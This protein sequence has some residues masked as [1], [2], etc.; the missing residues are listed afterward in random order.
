[1]END[2]V[3]HSMLDAGIIFSPGNNYVAVI[4]MYQPTQ[5]IFDVANYL[6]AQISAAIFNYFN[7]S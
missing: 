7:F 2:G 5:L 4:A 6:S 1:V 3:I